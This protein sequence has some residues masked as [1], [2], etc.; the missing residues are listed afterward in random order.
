MLTRTDDFPL[1]TVTVDGVS[2]RVDGV[3]RGVGVDKIDGVDDVHH[4]H[5][6]RMELPDILVL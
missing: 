5:D 1:T 6:V 4:A 2:G 3:S